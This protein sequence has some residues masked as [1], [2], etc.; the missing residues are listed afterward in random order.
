MDWYVF[1]YLQRISGEG[2]RVYSW[3]AEI[4]GTHVQVIRIKSVP[5]KEKLGS[6][7]FVLLSMIRCPSEPQR[8]DISSRTLRNSNRFNSIG[9]QRGLKIK[10]MKAFR[11]QKPTAPISPGVLMKQYNPPN[12]FT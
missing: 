10:Q 7:L 4:N 3:R 9:E 11:T 2:G 8:A 1:W 6:S 5:G 12:L